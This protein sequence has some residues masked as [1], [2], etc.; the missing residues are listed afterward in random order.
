MNRLPT[1]LGR[2]HVMAR[3]TACGNRIH[4]KALALPG[5]SLA[6]VACFVLDQPIA[7]AKPPEKRRSGRSVPGTGMEILGVLGRFRGPVLELHSEQSQ[8]TE[9]HRQ[10]PTRR[11]WEQKHER[12]LVTRCE[13]GH[14]IRATSPRRPPAGCPAARVRS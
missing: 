13:T 14:P 6:C 5:V 3:G 7:E 4:R 9:E 10:R 8:S 1:S 2:R 12:A 11:R